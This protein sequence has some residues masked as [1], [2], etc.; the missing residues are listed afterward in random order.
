MNKTRILWLVFTAAALAAFLI[1]CS[2]PAG[3]NGGE[4]DQIVPGQPGRNL[5]LT[6][7]VYNFDW[8]TQTY[9]PY[10]GN[11]TNVQVKL[12]DNIGGEFIFCG[13]GTMNNGILN[14]SIGTPPSLTPEATF[15]EIGLFPIVDTVSP[16]GAQ[17]NAS[18]GLSA[19]LGDIFI[20]RRVT[21][22]GTPSVDWISTWEE[23]SI[24][25]VDRNV[26]IT[27]LG[28]RSDDTST[29]GFT[30]FSEHKPYIINLYAGW[31]FISFREEYVYTAA[32]SGYTVTMS[33]ANPADVK[34]VKRINLE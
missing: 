2:N 10:T 30:D 19:E 9:T 21:E 32:K 17:F 15:L 13:D 27:S 31:N 25:Y 26:T 14:V 4:L 3:A 16:V 23:I 33:L 28:Y 6:G 22:S 18:T 7:Q 12:W 11:R 29:L 34:W 20:R 5:V 24:I 8:G 1:A